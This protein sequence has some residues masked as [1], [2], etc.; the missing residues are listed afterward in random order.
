VG[1]IDGDVRGAVDEVIR[2]SQGLTAKRSST[3]LTHPTAI[4]GRYQTVG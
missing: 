1:A 2:D 3:K 4:I